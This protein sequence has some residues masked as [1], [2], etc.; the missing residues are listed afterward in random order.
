M[1][2]KENT[3][4]FSLRCISLAILAMIIIALA[5]G[6][7]YSAEAQQSD[8]I[9]GYPGTARGNL[10]PFTSV[11][12]DSVV[13]GILFSTSLV[14]IAPN[15]SI[16]PWA[17]KSWE[18]K[19]ANNYTEVY[20]YIRENAIWSD[21]SPLRADDY[22]FTWNRIYMP[23]NKTLDPLGLSK[24][25]LSVEKAGDRVVKFIIAR[26]N[27]L[28]F[29]VIG[30]RIAVPQSSWA[31]IVSNITEADFSKLVLKP[32]DLGLRITLGPF[33]LE[34]YDPQTEIVL[35]ANKDF[36]M[37]SPKIEMF[38]IKLYQS[39]QALIPAIIK[40]EIDS[41]YFSPTDVP[42]VQGV[43]GVSVEPMPWSNNIFYLWTNNMIYPTNISSFR[44]ALSMAI[45]REVLAQRAGGGFGIARYNFIPPVAE[46][47]W[48]NREVNGTN[49]KYDPDMAN[50][51]LDSLGFIKG[52]DGIRVDKN[53][54]RLSFELAVPSI[55]DWLTAAQLIAS[56][57]QR[58]GIEVNIRLV[59][60]PTY[61]DIRNRGAFTIF[62]GS[63]IYSLSMLYDPA[64]FLFHPVFHSNSTSDIG[65]P[66]PGTNWARVRI[67]AIDDLIDNA[68]KTDNPLEYRDY[69]MKI[70]DV[71]HR[72]MTIIPLYS[73][74][75]IKVY[76]SDRV[77]GI[78]TGLQTQDTLLSV[79]K[80]LSQEQTR[81]QTPVITQIITIT[82]GSVT[83]AVVTTVATQSP[84]VTS[85]QAGQPAYMDILLVMAIA[86]AAL[87]IIG[88]LLALGRRKRS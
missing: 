12:V 25:V 35:K 49:T 7:P 80:K 73:I 41:C 45:N 86:I 36:F 40:G 27:T 23:F 48:L 52:P 18:F 51:I 3:M 14:Y 5:S 46:S 42:T 21:G 47:E 69:I 63:R 55:S 67:Q 10:N 53:G 64:S 29:T 1:V 74:Y 39:T 87:V 65:T 79:S 16:I 4:R 32:G 24:Y 13:T 66:T 58:I 82:T 33:A 68:L 43:P 81:A 78:Q 84:A 26:N 62:F 71:L 59:A 17:A 11:G 50:K 88:A 57:L 54:R 9:W 72:E 77:Q 8:Y 60:L 37:G 83:T 76:R 19:R 70:Q 34:Y 75:D 85:A 31:Q 22:V 15:G 20:F 30:G 44:I 2:W 28:I 61:V 56:D 6:L 38:R